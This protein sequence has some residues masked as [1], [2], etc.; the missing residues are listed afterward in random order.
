MG[1]RKNP[2]PT[3]RVNLAAATG[4]DGTIYVLGGSGDDGVPL[5]TVEAY[6]PSTNT[7]RPV[8]PMSTPRTNLAAVTGLDGTIYALGGANF[9]SGQLDTAEAYD[10]KADIWTPIASM[11]TRRGYPAAAVSQA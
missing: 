7:W 2:M 1:P 4:L 9:T 10:P 5:T 8:A 3:P 6:S 11:S